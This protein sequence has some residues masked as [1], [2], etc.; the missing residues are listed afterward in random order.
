[1]EEIREFSVLITNREQK[2]MVSDQKSKQCLPEPRTDSAPYATHKQNI[3]GKVRYLFIVPTYTH[4]SKQQQDK[5]ITSIRKLISNLDYLRVFTMQEKICS[6]LQRNKAL[7]L[8]GLQ[9]L[10]AAGVSELQCMQMLC[11]AESC[12]TLALET[13]LNSPVF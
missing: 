9:E 6:L 1:M 4:Y 2:Q 8:H 7:Y 11:F 13:A 10:P 3:S 5:N 12:L